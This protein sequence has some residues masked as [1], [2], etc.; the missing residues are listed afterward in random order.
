VSDD[1]TNGQDKARAGFEANETLAK[2]W[3]EFMSKMA[4]AGMDFDPRNLSQETQNTL[5]NA[6][7]QAMG[8]A[9]D[10]YMRSEAFGQSVRDMMQQAIQ[11]R[12]QMNDA[13]GQ[14]QFDMQAV[15]KQ[16][17]DFISAEIQHLHDQNERV[18][19]RLNKITEQLER[20]ASAVA[21]SPAPKRSKPTPT[22][23]KKT[24]RKA[25][26]AQKR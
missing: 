26:T 5:R 24:T 16:D 8:D 12:Q 18:S 22:T 21:P 7:F 1:P 19:E 6:M 9:C 25:K 11:F 14:V 17:M 13:L 15:T 2:F 3:T 4:T 20:L 10:E 23:K